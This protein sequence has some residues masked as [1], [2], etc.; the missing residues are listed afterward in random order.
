[1]TLF[2][3]SELARGSSTGNVL[4]SILAFEINSADC[5]SSACANTGMLDSAR[6]VRPT[7]FLFGVSRWQTSLAIVPSF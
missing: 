7:L 3:I 4:I 1:M 6:V 5:F 2:L